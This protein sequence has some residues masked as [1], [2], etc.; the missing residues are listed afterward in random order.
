MRFLLRADPGSDQIFKAGLFK[1]ESPPSPGVDLSCWRAA[2]AIF[3]LYPPH[4]HIWMSRSRL[5]KIKP[6]GLCSWGW[7]FRV[8]YFMCRCYSSTRFVQHSCSVCYFYVRDEAVSGRTCRSIPVTTHDRLVPH[9]WLVFFQIPRPR[10]GVRV[11]RTSQWGVRSKT[12]FGFSVDAWLIYRV[13]SS[14]SASFL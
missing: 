12:G 4:T 11:Q 7:V 2:D 13:M 1:A 14:L 5:C 8:I 9:S 6:S 10:I 3:L